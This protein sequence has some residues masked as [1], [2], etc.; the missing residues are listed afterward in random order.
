MFKRRK[1]PYISQLGSMDCGAACLAMI[2]NYYGLKVDIVDVGTS[3]H[4]GRDGMS[5]KSM[6]QAAISFGFE[7][8]AFRYDY[9]QENLQSKLPA[10]LC[11]ESHYVVVEKQLTNGDYLVVDP[12]SGKSA[13]TFDEIRKQYKD[14][15]VVIV[16]KGPIHY[17]KEKLKLDINK[18]DLAFV[19]FLM[20]LIQLITLC[21]PIIVQQVVDGLTSGKSLDFFRIMIEILVIIFA[22]FGISWIREYLLLNINTSIYKRTVTKMIHKLFKIDTNFFEWHSAGDISNRFNSINSLIDLVTNAFLNI[23]IQSITSI[24]CLIAMLL[25][26]RVLT[27]YAVLL[28]FLQISIM[29]LL[30]RKIKVKTK[31]YMYLQSDLQGELVDTLNNILEIKCMGMGNAISENVENKYSKLIQSFR[32]RGAANNLLNCIISTINV[33]FPLIIYMAG[34]ISIADGTMSIGKLIAF[35]T[36]VGYFTAPFNSISMI[37]PSLNSIKEILLRYKE[38]MNFSEN[39]HEGELVQETFERIQLDNISY[40]YSKAESKVLNNISL[41]IERGEKI[42]IIGLSGGGKSTLVKT[43]LGALQIENGDI[44][45]N[46]I[47]IN[48]IAKEQIY[49]WFSIVTQN[50]MC[51]NASVRKNVDITDSYSDEEVYKALKMAEIKEDILNMPLG[52]DTIVGDGGQNISGG[53]RQ[54]LA[55][56]RALI[57]NTDVIIFDE[58]TSNLDIITEKKIYDNLKKNKKTQILITHRLSSVVDSDRIY[59]LEKGKVIESGTHES[60]I[61]HKGWYYRSMNE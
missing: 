36:L 38:M 28:A 1:V 41:D 23:I 43:I 39:Q 9:V 34:S 40:S 7:F 14:I 54:R 6:K 46:G 10:I 15:L 51:L 13:V 21:V 45:I 35:V 27:F 18:S 42:S 33:I 31:E 8:T 30:N 56:A 53:Q 11:T 37:V 4:T 17:K 5:L 49:K 20:L 2:F 59:V 3:V 57:K 61:N 19:L 25:R 24:V 60:L 55:I 26:S 47:D 22:Y 32:G 50:P 58:A 52:M 44:N 12:A 48:N 29:T 16:P